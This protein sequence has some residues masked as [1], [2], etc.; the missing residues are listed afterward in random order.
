MSQGSITG[1]KIEVLFR[2]NFRAYDVIKKYD[3]VISHSTYP[4]LTYNDAV[5]TF[6]QKTGSG[7]WYTTI[8]LQNSDRLKV[9]ELYSI[10]VQFKASDGVLLDEWTSESIIYTSS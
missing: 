3:C 9:D 1:K 2:N 7:V 6:K 5:P 4:D 8:D 10:T